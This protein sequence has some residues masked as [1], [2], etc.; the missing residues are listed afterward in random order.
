[1]RIALGILAALA[2]LLLPGTA[3]AAISCSITSS[4]FVAAYD[5]NSGL[6]NVTAASF[7]V[8]CTKGLAGDPN[9]VNYSVRVNDGANPQGINNRASMGAQT[10]RYDVYRD[11]GCTSKW[12]GGTA[13]TGT[14][15]T[16]SVGTFSATSNFY[17]CILPG[18]TPAAGTYTDTVTMT[19]TLALSPSVTVTGTFGVTISTPATCSYSTPAA[20]LT[21]NYTSF[22]AAVNPTSSF[23]VTC[24]LG[25]VYTMALD[26]TAG[27]TLGLNYSLALSTPNS[28]GTGVQQTHSINGSMAAGQAGT[29]AGVC[30]STTARVITLTY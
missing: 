6:T 18:L 16:P 30:S 20:D 17:G 24:T 15:N 4:G 28:V 19:A 9:S 21:F 26:A 23:G 29:C 13:I 11:A 27:T 5:P 8:T 2:A 22:G 3:S 12:K 1:M 25:L 14:V 7:T 10:I